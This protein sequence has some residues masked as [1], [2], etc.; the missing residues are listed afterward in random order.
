ME[1]LR[2]GGGGV[3]SGDK[4]KCV[5]TALLVTNFYHTSKWIPVTEMNFKLLNMIFNKYK[6]QNNLWKFFNK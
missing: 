5:A 2:W 4:L 3:T 6:T 1:G